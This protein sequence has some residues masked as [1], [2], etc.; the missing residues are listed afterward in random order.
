MQARDGIAEPAAGGSRGW[1]FVL[2]APPTVQGIRFLA[3]LALAAFLLPEELGQAMLALLVILGASQLA[4][5][6]LDE[7]LVY[8]PRL[9]RAL[10]RRLEHTH[11][12]SGAVVSVLCALAG[13][14]LAARSS[15]PQLGRMLMAFAP[16]VWLANTSVLPTALL[17]RERAYRLVFLVD[18]FAVVAFSTTT[19][20]LAA[21]G[22]GAWS[23]VGGWYANAIVTV[24]VSRHFARPLLPQ[25]QEGSEEVAPI[26]RYG[27]HLTGAGLLNFLSERLDSFLVGGV[28]GTAMLGVYELGRHIAQWSENFFQS[29]AERGLFPVLAARHREQRLAEGYHESLRAGFVF[30]VPLNVLL[31]FLA[32]PAISTIYTGWLGRPAWEPAGPLLSVL[33]LA[34]GARC[35]ELAP[36]TALKAA[37]HSRI[38][39]MLGAIKLLLLAIVLPLCLSHGVRTVALGMLG[40]RTAGALAT[41]VAA[42]LR[43]ELARSD[44]SRWPPGLAACLLWSAAFA[45]AALW[46]TARFGEHAPQLLLILPPLALFL[47]GAVRFAVDRR[48]FLRDWSLVSM[49]ISRGKPR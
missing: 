27:A 34:A 32:I 39:L 31:C 33:A 14:A 35:V 46:I 43:P 25:E 40:V 17:V 7:G 1:R 28:L 49:R 36:Q 37:G 22:A 12:A 3:K 4:L 20:A 2:L 13:W 5:L 15:D 48:A 44:Q 41:W 47:W 9:T 16:M 8:A 24:L 26:L 18:V 10:W 45:P 6:G 21:T 38:V 19:I 23:L 11:H 29:L 30:A 42:S